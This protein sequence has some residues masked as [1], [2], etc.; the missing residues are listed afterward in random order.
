[1]WGRMMAWLREML[2]LVAPRRDYRDREAEA[3]LRSLRAQAEVQTG[4]RLDDDELR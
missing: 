4:R 2:G 3:I 1:M